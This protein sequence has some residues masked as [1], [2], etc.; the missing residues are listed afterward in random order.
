[1]KKLSSQMAGPHTHQGSTPPHPS[2]RPG[3]GAGNRS[4]RD[5]FHVLSPSR[6]P[7]GHGRA[8]VFGLHSD[9]DIALTLSQSADEETE[10]QRGDSDSWNG[11]PQV[12]VQTSSG[13]RVLQPLLRAPQTPSIGSRRVSRNKAPEGEPGSSAQNPTSTPPLLC[14]LR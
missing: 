2:T 9:P 7:T 4:C 11:W 5:W 10:A 8:A 1:M 13:A 14:D 3:S 6:Q 12:P